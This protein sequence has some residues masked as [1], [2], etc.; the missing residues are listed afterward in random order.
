MNEKTD[1]NR[2]V[3]Q[4]ER[5]TLGIK[6]RVPYLIVGER[7]FTLSC[8]PFEPCMYIQSEGELLNIIH[9]SFDP[10]WV[11][12]CF[13]EGDTFTSITGREYTPRD[14]C[15]LID[16]ASTSC[17]DTDISYVEGAIAVRKLKELGA[18][19]PEKAVDIGTLGFRTIS[20]R[21]SRSK[22]LTERVMYTDD[23]RVFVKIRA[24]SE[25]NYGSK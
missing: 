3:Y 14:F 22:K 25:A 13:A 2:V 8:Q 12:N 1:K 23:G 4:D 19:C 5:Y 24:N 16:F 20:D 9:N 21:F 7:T 6:D 17:Y 11:V 10:E 18:V 15:E